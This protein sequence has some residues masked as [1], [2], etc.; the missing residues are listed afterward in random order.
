MIQVEKGTGLK[1]VTFLN[2]PTDNSG[3]YYQN[4]SS[5]SRTVTTRKRSW[6]C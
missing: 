3:S 6:H 1:G 5:P 4:L 2:S